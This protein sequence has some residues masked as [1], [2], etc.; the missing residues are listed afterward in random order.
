MRLRLVWLR[1][2]CTG[3]VKLLRWSHQTKSGSS[4][5][6]CWDNNDINEETLSGTGTTH[7]T[8]GNV[9]QRQV[10]MVEL[11]HLD[12]T[13]SQKGKHVRHRLSFIPLQEPGLEY[14]VGLREGP[15]PIALEEDFVAS[16]MTMPSLL[17]RDFAWLVARLSST[18]RRKYG[19]DDGKRC[20]WVVS[21]QRFCFTRRITDATKRGWLLTSNPCF[22]D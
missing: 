6:F 8:N 17:K 11:Q 15:L 1:T 10:H 19:Q 20:A 21:V 12:R 9:V 4:A 18:E 5:T 7:Y 22:T 13:A 16:L 2:F 3:S 14:Y